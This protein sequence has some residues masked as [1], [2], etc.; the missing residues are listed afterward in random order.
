[1][2]LFTTGLRLNEFV[3]L[4]FKDFNFKEWLNNPKDTGKC[5]FIG[6]GN[7]EAIINIQSDI[8]ALIIKYINDSGGRGKD[9]KVF[10]V[11]KSGLAKILRINSINLLGKQIHIHTLR[12]SY[13]TYLLSKGLDLM[14]VKELLRHESLTSTQIYLHIN[15]EELKK[16]QKEAF[17]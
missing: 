7:K 11:S 5:R 4:K 9:E 6:K 1:L 13:A 15:Q 17:N 16:K 8:M 3:N 2:F 10:K 12:H 14:D